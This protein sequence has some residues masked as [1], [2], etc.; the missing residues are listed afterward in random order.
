MKSQQVLPNCHL[1]F[2]LSVA[3][4]CRGKKPSRPGTPHIGDILWDFM[5][6]CWLDAEHRPSAKM[7]LEFTRR[8][9]EVSEGKF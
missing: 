1:T 9:L 6:K 5:Q 8:Q 7:V 3:S 4:C 2:I